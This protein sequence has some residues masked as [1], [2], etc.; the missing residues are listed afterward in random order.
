[1]HIA[2]RI[3]CLIV[4]LLACG[5]CGGCDCAHRP[6]QAADHHRRRADRTFREEELADPTPACGTSAGSLE[7][8]PDEWLFAGNVTAESWVRVSSELRLRD[9]EFVVD[10]ATMPAIMVQA[11]DLDTA[12]TILDRELNPSE[13]SGSLVG[14]GS[15]QGDCTK[16]HLPTK[17]SVR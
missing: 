16:S 5:C 14:V 9:V 2:K 11:H 1:M 4:A 10:T 12:R 17:S 6:S 3:R 15:K 7:P 8:D 13:V